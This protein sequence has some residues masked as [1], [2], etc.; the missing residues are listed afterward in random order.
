MDEHGTKITDIIQ[1]IKRTV[2]NKSSVIKGGVPPD[3][4]RHKNIPDAAHR[5]DMK[6]RGDVYRLR[7]INQAGSRRR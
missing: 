7:C 4:R 1:I 3:R 6:S 5:H 2:K